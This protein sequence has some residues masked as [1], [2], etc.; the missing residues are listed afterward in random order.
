MKHTELRKKYLEFFKSKGHTVV[1]SDS[2]IPAGDPTLLFTGAGMIQFKNE[3]M[4]NIKGYTRATSCQKCMRT[5]DV[6]NVG[7]TAYHHTFFE[8]LGNFSFGDYFKEEA[9]SWAWEFML[10]VLKIPEEKLWVSVYREDKEAYDIWKDKIK[11]PIE[12]IVKLG[13]KDNFWPSEAKDKGPNGPC[14]PCSEIFYDYGKETGCG[15]ESCTPACDCG[16]FVEVWNL[17]FTQFERKDNGVLDALPNKNIDTGMGLERLCAVMQGVK[18]NFQTDIF[19][20][21]L[22]AIEKEVQTADD[23]QRTTNNEQRTSGV[24]QFRHG[25]SAKETDRGWN[26]QAGELGVVRYVE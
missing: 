7:R 16:R 2:L 11:I 10:D 8:M 9:I 17:V 19:A 6:E 5:G 14:G 20:P 12:R 26:L 15:K 13:Q 22:G 25:L 4:G 21:I 24:Y 3:F 1:A 18:S 23:K